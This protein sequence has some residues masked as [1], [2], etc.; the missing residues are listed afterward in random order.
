MLL[1]GL[2]NAPVRIVNYLLE[3]ENGALLEEVE[4]LFDDETK[5]FV[6]VWLRRMITNLA[7]TRFYYP[8][9]TESRYHLT[10][11]AKDMIAHIRRFDMK[12]KE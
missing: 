10:P 12:R 5:V 9:S 11:F 2:V 3:A 4:N 8:S 1:D 6:K 7:V